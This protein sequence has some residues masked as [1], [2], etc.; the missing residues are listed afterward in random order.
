MTTN[1]VLYGRIGGTPTIPI[2]E[3]S[4]GDDSDSIVSTSPANAGGAAANFMI[5]G[6]NTSTSFGGRVLDSVGIIKVGTGTFTLT[7]GT[8][9]YSG[10]TAVS[11][12]VLAFATA[13]PS[14]S[15]TYS[16]LAPGILD[17]SAVGGILD[18]GSTG[19]QTIRGD[20]TLRGSLNLGGTGVMAAGLS[21]RIGTLTITNDATLGGTVFMELSRTNG[22]GGTNDQLVAKTITLGGTLNVTNIG[23]TLH[24]G[25]TFKL[26]RATSTL[27]GSFSAVNFAP[28]DGNNMAYT[29]ADNTAVD[30]SITVLS[31][32]NA[33]N[34][35]PTNI[36]YTF[37]GNQITLSWPA[38][39][40]GWRLQAQTNSTSV[41]LT[42][43]WFDVA[44]STT[45]NQVIMPVAPANG[46]VF[47]RMIYP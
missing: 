38:D 17:V 6:L 20:G 8:L 3:L 37:D 34:T 45:T 12:G 46:C 25:D 35:T 26:F 44:G 42:A 27:S 22:S 19:N 40:I 30:G 1:V 29:F 31:V 7:N 43:T 2:G 28:T 16:L 23:S 14:A 47:Y 9:S 5:G 15:A 39:H 36:T 24:V 11:N 4:G 32:T 18:V 21:N 41:G 13:L 33:V 10:I